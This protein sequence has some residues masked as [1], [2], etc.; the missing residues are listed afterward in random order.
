MLL[1]SGFKTLADVLS[2]EAP[3]LADVISREAPAK[4][5]CSNDGARC[6][7][8]G[9][10]PPCSDRSSKSTSRTCLNDGLDQ[11]EIA[12]DS[13]TMVPRQTTSSHDR[14]TAAGPLP[15]SA[16]C[17]FTSPEP[18]PLSPGTSN[19]MPTRFCQVDEGIGCGLRKNGTEMMMG[20]L[21]K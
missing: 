5:D 17:R 16:H 7:S 9:V 4:S 19:G 10:V 13:V 18:N 3:T 8:S 21:Q 1:K 6:L 15:L 12:Q 2:R 20:H 14:S 11:I